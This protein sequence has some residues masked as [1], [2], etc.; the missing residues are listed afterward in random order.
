MA[1]TLE[2]KRYAISEVYP[3]AG[4]KQKCMY[5]PANQVCAIYQSFLNS[6]RFT[7]NRNKSKPASKGFYHQISIKEYLE[8]LNNGK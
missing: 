6:G 4:W 7:K 5:M 2:Q 8:G 3:G 1:Y